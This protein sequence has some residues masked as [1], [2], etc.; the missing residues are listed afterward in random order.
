VMP[1]RE[2][3]ARAALMLQQML[4]ANIGICVKN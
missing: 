4:V 2:R 1:S 3:R